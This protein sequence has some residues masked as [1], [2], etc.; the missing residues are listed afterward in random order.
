MAA[1]VFTT[2]VGTAT[3]DPSTTPNW[4]FAPSAAFISHLQGGAQFKNADGTWKT[5]TEI[6]ILLTQPGAAVANPAPQQRRSKP[7][8]Y[9]DVKNILSP[10]SLGNLQVIATLPRILD[11]INANNI[12]PVVAWAELLY[13]NGVDSK[14]TALEMDSIMALAESTQLDPTWEPAVPGPSDLEANFQ[15]GSIDHRMITAAT[16][17]L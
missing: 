10:Q 8:G 9:A 4:T 15:V 14:I 11:D 7:F 2:P 5:A 13:N 6:G 3:F 12:G 1:Q 17:V 16:G